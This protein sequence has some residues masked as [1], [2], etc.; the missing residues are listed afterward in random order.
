MTEIVNSCNIDEPDPRRVVLNLLRV[1][2]GGVLSA[3]EAVRAGALF[4]ISANSM[5]VTLARLTRA[6]LIEAEARG[7]YRLGPAGR[8][9]AADIAGWREAESRLV[10]WRGRWVAAA[11][12]GLPRSD[13]RILRARERALSMLGMRELENGLYVRPDNLAGGI[14]AVRRRL[15]DL[16]L[17][18]QAAVFAAGDLDPAREAA[19]RELWASQRLEAGYREGVARLDGWAK[20]AAALSPDIAA[21]ESFL[22]G[23]DAIRAIVFDPMLPAPLVDE[24]ERRA[25]IA[26]ARRFD[27]LGRRIWDDFL[28]RTASRAQGPSVVETM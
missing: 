9:I 22:L 24:G 2:D 5:R 16:G 18:K 15:H 14:A 11:T 17:E 26:A 3:P 4:G 12:G 19:A 20:K 21:R 28:G 7:L 10:P 8:A 27:D 6:G 25:F 13:R 23:D 1:A